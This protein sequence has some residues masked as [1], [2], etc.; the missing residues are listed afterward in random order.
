MQRMPAVSPFRESDLLR[1][2]FET[3]VARC[4]TEGLVSGQRLAVDASLI[5]AD[6]NRQN[7]TSKEEWQ[8][9]KVDPEDAPRAMREYLAT[10]AGVV[11]HDRQ[12]LVAPKQPIFSV[13]V[14]DLRLCQ[15]ETLAEF[16]AKGRRAS[17]RRDV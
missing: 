3:V 9:D 10:A 17:P 16:G 4:V 8:P 12:V 6:A 1:Q 13:G 14:A 7:S 15:Q 11:G 2:V 5:E